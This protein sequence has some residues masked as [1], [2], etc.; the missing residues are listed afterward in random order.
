MCYKEINIEKRY[1][2]SNIKR[3]NVSMCAG[4]FFTSRS[5]EGRTRNLF[6]RCRQLARRVR[7]GAKVGVVWVVEVLWHLMTRFFFFG[8]MLLSLFSFSEAEASKEK[9]MWLESS[10]EWF[11]FPRL[12]LGRGASSFSILLNTSPGMLLR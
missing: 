5:K 4:T 12:V 11:T 2:E 3:R 10:F 8:R 6:P 7:G 1:T 9:R